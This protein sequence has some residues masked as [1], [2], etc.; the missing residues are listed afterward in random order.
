MDN[1]ENTEQDNESEN[2]VDEINIHDDT[3]NQHSNRDEE[4]YLCPDDNFDDFLV[5]T[6]DPQFIEDNNTA[7]GLNIEE[8]EICVEI[9]TTNAGREAMQ[10]EQRTEY[11][12]TSNKINIAGHVLLNQCG[13]LLS[14]KKHV[15][16]GSSKH[17]Y[18][19]DRMCATLPKTAIPLVYPEGILFQGIHYQAANDKCSLVGCIPTPLMTENIRKMRFASIASHVRSRLTNTSSSTCSDPRYLCFCYD[20]M[21][22]MAA[23]HED[24]RLILNRG[25]TVGDDKTGGLGL[26]GKGDTNLFHSIDNKQMVRNL[27]FSQKYHQWDYFLTFTCNQKNH[28]GTSPIKNWI[29]NKGWTSHYP[30][31]SILEEDEKEEISDA[32]LRTASNLLLQIWEEVTALL[33]NYLQKSVSS[34]FKKLCAIFLRKEYQNLRGNLSHAHSLLQFRWSLIT[35][36]EK[37]CVEDLVRASVCDI[38]RQ[39]EVT[40]YIAD[41]I[42]ESSEDKEEIEHYAIKFLGHICNDACKVRKADGTFQCRKMTI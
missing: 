28:F 15:I 1:T 9:P 5:D 22:N 26:R 34:P 3:H 2:S 6:D 14:R 4:G 11:G 39:S 32:I 25:L 7:L 17:H 33:V 37:E 19:L 21:S 10:I 31:Y 29:D 41:G 20:I 13:T 8:T 38:V 18:L 30:D 23:S 27:C 35:D 12:G 40:H 36:E 42:F 16:K 24:T